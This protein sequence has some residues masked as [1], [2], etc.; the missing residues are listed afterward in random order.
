M[1][2][3]FEKMD[4]RMKKQEQ[5]LRDISNHTWNYGGGNSGGGGGSGYRKLRNT[6]KYCWSHGVRTFQCQL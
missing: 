1:T 3:F 2:L 5:S 4:D 6:S